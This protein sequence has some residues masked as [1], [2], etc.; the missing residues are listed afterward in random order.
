MLSSGE[1]FSKAEDLA[2]S[3]LGIDPQLAV[4]HLSMARVKA[5]TW[6][7]AGALNEIQ[8]SLDLDPNLAEAHVL[9]AYHYQ[10]R[11]EKEKGRAEMEKAL[12]LDPQSTIIQQYAGTFYLYDGQLEKAVGFYRK[13][14]A[15]N[16][17]SEHSQGNLGLSYVRMGMYDDGIRE[18]K[19]A[20]ESSNLFS[21]SRSTD[22]VY[23]YAKAGRNNEARELIREMLKFYE[24][25]HSGAASLAFAFAAVGET[26][27]AFE[28]LETAYADRSGYLQG[29]AVD[30]SFEELHSDPRFK[31]FITKLGLAA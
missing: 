11:L 23:A 7:F 16:P 21:P 14:L 22:L 20:A 30:F 24:E 8:K 26:D 28:W 10:W 15:K 29:I 18:I 4:A 1:A 27:R 31:A 12:E 6:D 3:A 2:R 13:V 19:K 5:N 17:A 9:L 25:H